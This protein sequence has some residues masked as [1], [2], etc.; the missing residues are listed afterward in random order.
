M[1]NPVKGQVA[2]QLGDLELTLEFTIDALCALEGRLD[3]TARQILARLTT[4][5][6][7]TFVRALL[8]AGLRE[9]HT[10]TERQ[11]GELMRGPGRRQIRVKAVA[12]FLSA[13]PSDEEDEADARPPKRPPGATR[14]R[15]AAQAGSGP[16]SLS[17]GAVTA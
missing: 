11:A 4:D 15:T 14:T 17:S 16:D 9:H 7:M 10:Y 5:D 12:A 8:W 3:L 6:S 13:W 1:T 2:L